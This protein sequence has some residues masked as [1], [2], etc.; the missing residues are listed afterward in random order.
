[1]TSDAGLQPTVHELDVCLRAPVTVLSA[2][3]GAVRG[4]GAEGVFCGD[5]R[6]L[7][8]VGVTVAGRRPDGIGGGSTGPGTS[9]HVAVVRGLGDPG[10]D[11]TVRLETVRTLT[12][13]GL[14]ETL[15]LVSTAAAPVTAEVVLTLAT[16]LAT[17]EEVKSGHLRPLL[18]P[19]GDGWS[20]RG[21]TV[22]VPGLQV[23]GEVG[24]LRWSVVVP[25]RDAVELTWS[26]TV[27]DPGGVTTAPRTAASWSTPRV[28][29][30]DSRLAALVEQSLEDLAGLRMTTTSDPDDVFAAAGAPWYLTLF[31]RDSLWTARLLLP[32]G[33]E[34]AAGTLRTLAARQGTRRDD[35]TGEEPGKILH[36][37]RRPPVAEEGTTPFLPP[38]YFGTVDATPLWVCLLHDAWRWG[39]DPAVVTE[40]LDPLERALGWL[41]T[42]GDP[43]G[44][45]F[46]EYLDRSGAGLANQGWKDSADSVRF[47]D[48][49]IAEGP[50]ALCE[51]Q[52]YAHEAALAGAHLLEAFG[53]P[54]ADRWRAW[55][56]DLAECFRGAFW[57]ADAEGRYPAIAL[58]GAKT[59]VDAPTSNIGH[60]LGTGL[61]TAGE[62]AEVAARLGS[63]AMD[64]GFGLRTMAT[65]AGGYG[66]LTYHCGSVWPHDTAITLTGL[67]RDGHDAVAGSLARGVLAAG[68]SFAWRLPELFAGDG[69]DVVRRALAYPASCRPQAWSAAAAVAVLTAVLGLRPD[70]P[71]GRLV[72][73]PLQPAPLG[74][75][76]VEGLRIGSD[77]VTVTVSADGAV[78]VTG[79][80]GEVAVG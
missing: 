18:R 53:R 56:A 10:P 15:R 66:P 54:G 68:E 31:G 55:A 65:T 3:D 7:S 51:A 74:A 79:F 32:L 11:P 33:T 40:L 48:G 69:S 45:G 61:L 64:S 29:A 44:D 16:D 57:V 25:P 38:V 24:R 42:D 13:D 8:V 30:D 6:A 37:I 75:V 23:D 28:T 12:A 20:G 52:A 41:A 4:Q 60:L 21:V 71:A 76:R 47:A 2:R 36:E 17:V 78:E 14:T 67:A 77:D 22:A 26:A 1:M 63:P 27:T 9:T 5:V 46:L 39:L 43:D 73:R 19:D 35:A 80:S 70:V 49:T 59:P 62:S 34:L 72:V 50:I 58:D